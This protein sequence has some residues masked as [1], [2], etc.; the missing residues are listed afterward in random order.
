MSILRQATPEALSRAVSAGL[1]IAVLAFVALS[2]GRTLLTN[3][4]FERMN[5][6]TTLGDAYG[7]AS[8]AADAEESLDHLY[9]LAPAL[10][11]RTQ[12]LDAATALVASLLAV[13]RHGTAADIRLVDRVLLDHTAYLAASAQLYAAIDGGD[14]L[15][16]RAID[17]RPDDAE[18]GNIADI[19]GAAAA[20]HAADEL[21]ARQELARTEHVVSIAAPVASVIALAFA[22]LIWTVIRMYQL[23]LDEAAR[24]RVGSAEQVAAAVRDSE[25]RYRGIVETA[26]EGVW[27]V[28]SGAKTT[29]VNRRLAEMLGYTVDEMLGRSLFEFMEEGDRALVAENLHRRRQGIPAEF[30]F[31]FVRKGGSP[32][33]TIVHASGLHDQAGG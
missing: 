23:R 16:A 3:R 12:H 31:K 7:D 17:G 24:E 27:T 19:L 26:A 14:V 25:Q 21:Q 13:R 5:V 6:A 8:A 10:N 4:A 22:A 30:E 11:L 2:T 1:I 33:W 15:L 18:L 28:D 9:E 32:V 20:R 29:F